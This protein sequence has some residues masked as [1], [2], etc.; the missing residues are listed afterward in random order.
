MNDQTGVI[1]F[2]R[3]KDTTDGLRIEPMGDY[4]SQLIQIE[5]W[6]QE[7]NRPL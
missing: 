7:N 5:A 4:F 3:P 1:G 2:G 6:D